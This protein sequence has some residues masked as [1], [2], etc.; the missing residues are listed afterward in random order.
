MSRFKQAI[1][2]KE[3]ESALLKHPLREIDEQVKKDYIKGLVFVA[4]ADE[5][6]HD[7]EKSYVVS[8]MK[9]IGLDEGL[10]GEFEI[11]A[12][13]CEDE[14]VI[15][16]MDRLKAFEE[17]MKI[18]FMIEV[19]VISFKD[20]E[21]DESEQNM[22]NDYLEILE[23]SDKKD[24]IMYLS[25]AL[26]NKD[27]DLALSFY[28][29]KKEMFL[30]FDYMFVMADIDI[31]KELKSLYSWEWI[32][33]RMTRGEVIANN[34]VA[35]KAVS[36]RQTCVF[37]NSLLISCELKQVVNTTQ[38]EYENDTDEKLS[39]IKKIE[40]TNLN[41]SNDFFKYDDSMK[42]DDFLCSAEEVNLFA[43]F[44]NFINKNSGF[45]VGLLELSSVNGAANASISIDSSIEPFIKSDE[46]FILNSELR[47]LNA[48][49]YSNYQIDTTGNYAFRLMQVKENLGS[50]F[51][52]RTRVWV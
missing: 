30:K 31:E 36:V 37:L 38:F 20:G 23:I 6:F 41:Y 9:N 13:E 7:D 25:T 19:V 39:V 42:D 1:K 51:G 5:N 14:E 3:L 8:L 15:A 47:K 40:H 21:F 33:W 18:N 50:L 32:E 45:N 35:S 11:F 24:D 28:T 22:F 48:V 34:L 10:L 49:H 26:I 52:L 43:I 4:T 16:F 44:S 12:K 17:D 29:A 2:T 27:V 46:I